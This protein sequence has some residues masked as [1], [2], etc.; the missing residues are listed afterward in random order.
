ATLRTSR[1]RAARRALARRLSLWPRSGRQSPR[2][3]YAANPRA[4]VRRD[5]SQSGRRRVR[6]SGLAWLSFILLLKGAC[7]TALNPPL[8]A[9]AIALGH[10]WV[11]S[12]AGAGRLI[13]SK[14]QPR[15]GTSSLRRWL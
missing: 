7:V 14:L 5:R 9:P 11:S 13:T 15:V 6:P 1:R 12:G 4:V 3:S 2:P 10:L 8:A